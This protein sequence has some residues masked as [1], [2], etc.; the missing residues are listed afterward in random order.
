MYAPP[1]NE[2]KYPVIGDPPFAEVVKFKVNCRS[3]AIT[4][5]KVGAVGTVAALNVKIV[6]ALAAR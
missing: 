5:F 4:E 2:Y 1:F 3:P 6:E